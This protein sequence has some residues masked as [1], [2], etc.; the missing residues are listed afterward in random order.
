MIRALRLCLAAAAL[1]ALCAS[2]TALASTAH[3]NVH[4]KPSK[5]CHRRSW[6]AHHPHR[7]H[8]KRHG[9]V[10]APASLEISST[11]PLAAAPILQAAAPAVAAAVAPAASLP[12]PAIEPS[13]VPSPV[14]PQGEPPSI[15]H[16]QV[17]AVEY[18]FSLSRTTVP[19]GRVVLQFVNNGQDPH[20]L[21]LE[22]AEGPLSEAIGNTPAKG[23][24]DLELDLRAGSYTLF[25]SLP[26]HAAKGMKATLTVE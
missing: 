13:E 25:C 11:G 19:A 5:K 14:E 16:V 12:T 20:N 8:V 3:G 17:S 1:C 21:N 15:P 2:A 22:T 7:C 24:G 9:A 6:R 18:S 4:A 23:I 10:P 26:T